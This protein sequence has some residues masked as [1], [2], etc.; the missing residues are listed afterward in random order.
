MS[1]YTIQY[2]KLADYSTCFVPVLKSASCYVLVHVRNLS[3]HNVLYTLPHCEPHVTNCLNG[4]D[5]HIV[6]I[7]LC[8]DCSMLH[9]KLSVHVYS[10]LHALH[11]YFPQL[12]SCTGTLFTTIEHDSVTRHVSKDLYLAKV[13]HT[14][15][16][17]ILIQFI[18]LYIV[19][20][21]NTV[22]DN[23]SASFW[24]FLNTRLTVLLVVA[25]SHWSMNVKLTLELLYCSW[26]STLLKYVLY[27][28]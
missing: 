8:T 16:V 28:M 13:I 17:F 5:I 14:Q 9:V 12:S 1:N 21:S 10:I 25:H 23:Y 6:S 26:F 27:S 2:K 15:Y 22:W 19:P 24:M 7:R 4:V 18:V 20:S 11:S 3:V